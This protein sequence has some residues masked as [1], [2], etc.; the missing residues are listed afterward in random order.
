MTAWKVLGIFNY[1]LVLVYGL[2]LSV[3]IAGGCQNRRQK[4]IVA[5]VGPVFLLVQS[6]CWLLFGVA[7]ARQIY[8]LIVHLPLTLILILVLKKP[9]GEAIVCTCTAYLCCQLPRWVDIAVSWL[10][11][12]PLLGEIAYTVAIFP[13]F[14]LLLSRFA[15]PAHQAMTRSRQSLLLFGGLPAGYYLFDY[16]TTIYSSLLYSGIPALNELT[17][18]VVI[19]FYVLFLTAYNQET[20]KLA[21]AELELTAHMSL[22]NQAQREMEALRQAQTQTAIFR[23]DLRHHLNIIE[24]FLSADK[25]QQA[26]SY[27]QKAQ[28]RVSATAVQRFCDNETVN[29]LCSSFAQKAKEQD[30]RLQV[31]A[32]LPKELPISDTELCALLS[33]GLEN[34]LNA[35]GALPPENRWV[36]CFF[37][38]RRDKLL[39]EIQNP[40]VGT[41]TMADGLPENTAPGHGFGCRSIRYIAQHRGGLYTFRPENG[42]FTLQVVL[43]LST[44]QA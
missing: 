30:T 11:R 21:Q 12:S 24:G 15:G 25:P 42:I 32:R 18:T 7:V 37:G 20:Q 41:V 19:L 9:V 3:G 38:I 35:A 13:L 14:F 27:I 28:T 40:Y 43:P 26:L 6:V 36:R 5:A 29:L 31:E 10:F 4:R 16:A 33:N 1:G 23:H 34:A 22:L 17:P 44:D 39:L 2:F 8:P